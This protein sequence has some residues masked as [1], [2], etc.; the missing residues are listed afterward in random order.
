MALNDVMAL[1]EEERIASLLELASSD[2]NGTEPQQLIGALLAVVDGSSGDPEQRVAIGELLARYGDPRLHMPSDPEYFVSVGVHLETLYVGRFPVTMAE[3]REFVTS[4]AYNDDA[5]WSE[6]GLA[7]KADSSDTWA[8]KIDTLD[9]CL[10]GANQ[11]AIFVNWYEAQAYATASGARL[12]S[13][14]ERLHVMR[15]EAKRPYPWGAPFGSGNANTAEEVLK[16]P[17][18]VGLYHRDSTP[19]GV[20]DLAGNVAE[21]LGDDVASNRLIHPGAWSQPSMASWAKARFLIEPD[22]RG[23]DLGFRLVRDA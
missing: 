5:N 18:A 14:M 1:P 3:F 19:E 8:D 21:W 9:A 12:P 11:P 6:R 23:P 7:W 13:Q 15:G 16:R 4:A 22:F 20:M 10:V 17:C 2:S